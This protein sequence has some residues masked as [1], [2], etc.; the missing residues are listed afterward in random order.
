MIKQFLIYLSVI[1]V[2]ISCSFG[3]PDKPKNLISKK[4][5]V[6]ILIDARLIGS[7]SMAHKQKMQSKGIKL[8]SYVFKKYGI[9]SLQ[10]ALSNAYYAYHLK[11]YEAIY[12]KVND[13]LESLKKTLKAQNDKEESANKKREKDSLNALKAKDTLKVAIKKDSLK[14]DA[15]KIKK[16][17]DNSEGVLIKPVSDKARQSRK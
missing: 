2:V 14:V 16:Q 13:S 15:L 5:M 11:D 8:D 1:C 6:N 4:D 12:N 9:D 17:I 3:G 10:F 7:A